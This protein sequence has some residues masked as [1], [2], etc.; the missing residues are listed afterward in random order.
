M[1]W[2][3]TVI[4]NAIRQPL[5][6]QGFH[7]AKSLPS[8][9]DLELRPPYEVAQRLAA[10]AVVGTWVCAN[11]AQAPWGVVAPWADVHGLWAFAS[12]RER[13]MLDTPRAT[14]NEDCL[15][16]IGWSFE[17]AWSLAWLL[18]FE[19]CPLEEFGMMSGDRV[20]A[21]AA[22][23]PKVDTDPDLRAWS[24]S[25]PI[26]DEEVAIQFE[27]ALYCLHNAGRSAATG[28][29]DAVPDWFHPIRDTGAI[30]ERRHGLSWAL[31]PGVEWDDVDL[32]T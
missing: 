3:V 1:L 16:D 28:A 10:I 19:D 4:R 15:G 29:L 12:R 21:V 26:R 27:D 22:Y 6:D 9:R 24:A 32:S 23:G 17:G 11:E 2:D 14:A 20:T 31:S 8:K 5:E 18:G 13:A 25:H 7:W 30:Q